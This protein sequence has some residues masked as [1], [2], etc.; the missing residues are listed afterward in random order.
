MTPVV[1]YSL[2][3]AGSHTA[4]RSLAK[5]DST[6]TQGTSPDTPGHK[7]TCFFN[8]GDTFKVLEGLG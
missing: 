1:G 7:H 3:G 5:F 4:G 2:A 6:S 8:G